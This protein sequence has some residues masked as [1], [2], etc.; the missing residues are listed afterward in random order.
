MV[1]YS[2]IFQTERHEKK[3][4]NTANLETEEERRTRWRS[5]R[6]MY[7]TAFMLMAGLS[8]TVTST[9]PYMNK[10][11]PNAGKEFLGMVVAAGALGQMIFSPIFGFWGN[12]AKSVRLPLIVSLPIT[13]LTHVGCALL[14][15]FPTHTVRYW[16]LFFRFLGGSTLASSV[17][18]RSYV[19]EATT[20]RERTGAISMI[21]LSLMTG[22]MLGQA[23]QVAVSPLGDVGVPMFGGALWLNMYTAV[24]WMMAIVHLIVVV[25]LVWPGVFVEQRITVREATASNNDNSEKKMKIEEIKLDYIAIWSIIVSFSIACIS[26]FDTLGASIV[27]DQ[28]AWSREEALKFISTL[29]TCGGICNIVVVSVM[30]PLCRRFDERSVLIYGA[31]GLLSLGMYVNIPWGGSTPQLLVTDNIMNNTATNSTALGCPVDKQPWCAT[32][33]AMTVP[34]L[35]IG[36]VPGS[37]GRT[38]AI[39]LCQTII[40]KVLGPRPQGVWLGLMMSANSL[41]RVIGPVGISSIYVRLGPVWTFSLTGVVV[42]GTPLGQ[43]IFSPIVGYWG[44]HANDVRLPMIVALPIAALTYV[45][46]ALL[47]LFPAHTVRY[48]MLFI[49]I[50]IGFTIGSSVVCRSYVAEATTIRERTGV[51]SMI[52]LYL[53]LGVM[54][55]QIL[56][57]AVT[58]LGDEGIPLF[59]G[60]LWLNMYTAI[61]WIN[62]VIQLAM[63]GVLVWPNMFIEQRIALREATAKHKESLVSI[64][65]PLCRRFD[66]RSVLIIG[67]ALTAFAQH[68]KE[69]NHTTDL[70]SDLERKIRWRSIRIVYFTMFMFSLSMSMSMTGIWP[71][72]NKL[73]PSAGK[74]FLGL[75]VAAGALGQM[76]FSPIFGYWASSVVCRSYVAEAT[77]IRER[78]GVIS[79]IS[80]NLG[81]GMML[82]QVSQVAVTPLGD[83]G[84]PLFGGT[85]WLNMYTAIA[86]IN[87]VIQLVI[88][89]VLMWPNMFIEQRIAIREASSKHKESLVLL[90]ASLA[91]DEFAWS[92]EEALKFMSILMTCGGICN[93][94]VISIIKPLCRR[95]DERSIL[96]YLGFAVTAVSQLGASLAMDEFAWSREEALKFMSILMTCGGIFNIVIVSIIKPLCRRFD[97]RSVLI[98]AGF[99]VTAVSQYVNI[100]WNPATTN[101]TALGCP[102]DRQP[103]CATAP[104]MTVTQLVIG[105]LLTS[106]GRASSITLCQTIFSKVLGPRPQGVWVG[107]MMSSSCFARVISPIIITSI[108][109]Q[110][111][112]VWTFAMTGAILTLCCMWLQ[113]V[114]ARLVPP[115]AADEGTSHVTPRD[116]ELQKLWTHDNK[117]QIVATNVEK[118]SKLDI[119][120]SKELLGV[121]VASGWL[122][123]M[124]FSPVVGYWSSYTESARM[125]LSVSMPLAAMASIG[126]GILEIFPT[127]TAS[128]WM[129]VFRFLI[130]VSKASSSVVCRSYVAEATTLAERTGAISMIAIWLILGNIIGNVLQGAVTPL[131]DAGISIFAEA[132]S[133]NMYNAPVCINLIIVVV[134][135]VVLVWPGNFNEWRIA[136]KEAIANQQNVTNTVENEN[137]TSS[138]GCPVDSQSWCEYTPAMTVIQVVIGHIVFQA[139]MAFGRLLSQAILS[140]VVGP[141]SQSYPG[142]LDLRAAGS[143]LDLLTLGG[144]LD[145]LLYLALALIKHDTDK[146]V[147]HKTEDLETS[148]EYKKRWRSLRIIYFSMFVLSMTYF[149][150][151]AGVWPYLNKLDPTADKEFLGIAISAVGLGQM[152]F[153]ILAGYWITK[154]EST[155]IPLV[156]FLLISIVATSG[157]A[158][159]EV[160]PTHAIRYWMVLFR[161]FIGA[162]VAITVICRSY[163]ADSTTLQ[164]RTIAI[165]SMTLFLTC[166]SLTSNGTSMVM[167]HFAW[168]RGEALQ[169][170][171]L[172][173]TVGNI[174]NIITIIVLRPLCRRFEERSILLN[175]GL[176]T[177]ILGPLICIPFGTNPP[178][179]MTIDDSMNGVN[180]TALGCPVDV[181]SWCA[182]TP[183][184]R[185]LPMVTGFIV[186]RIGRSLSLTL[187]QTIFSK[188]LGHRP[189]GVWIGVLMTFV[190][191]ARVVSPVFLSTVYVRLGPIWTF[192]LSAT[193]NAL[194]AFWLH[195]VK[196]RLMPP[197]IKTSHKKSD[198]TGSEVEVHM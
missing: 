34:Q 169:F 123:Q 55:G 69:T 73:D 52:G 152:V 95:F 6:I 85:L 108:Y 33:S 113:L 94:V 61:A 162:S 154:V 36:F 173:M 92:R 172:L 191:L 70:E 125:P 46:Y 96:I 121:V 72:L 182:T 17:V 93:I 139:G 90:G 122:G 179:I 142:E 133:F 63:F 195:L 132:M 134:V 47:E 79:M 187:C 174:V 58:P 140:K 131:G 120:A 12:H 129:V 74:E 194:C 41:S 14:E 167:D 45:G 51:I 62:V 141:I 86:W 138:L 2:K 24:G 198:E 76:I 88:F 146:P 87:V 157:Y 4:Y 75:I 119:S 71:Y 164:E 137:S 185:I 193:L 37:I 99:A 150:A 184:M 29:M 189:Q 117:I 67:L 28:F 64:M 118:S 19:A 22:T 39:T 50:V 84:I 177:M 181:Q 151:M 188:V 114:R 161:F 170:M 166:G 176:T 78:T 135:F 124:L 8:T 9:W 32:S 180:G 127:N 175:C 155:R 197:Q 111:G 66:E 196:T 16:M 83:E 102:V 130:G 57:V 56:Q 178:Q 144:H 104:A 105:Y 38:V 145:S 147:V 59:G 20:I 149:V 53:G 158:L 160:F 153:S 31:F 1:F 48:W 11:D 112:P 148:E 40:S 25:V 136:I 10:L 43:M 110:L 18:C 44:N 100:P 106:I 89:G 81:L 126:Y 159:L 27:M 21:S 190:C 116:E 54:C 30:K 26:V 3:T 143:G 65:K 186:I 192:S 23:L 13:A 35:L 7:F 82:G 107:V 128:Y 60:T 171:T 163:I 109:V 156:A 42:A 97:E 165:N 5:I 68:E 77:T 98:Y 183:S 49:R 115:R 103:W 15:T 168:S 91:M 80:L 101:I